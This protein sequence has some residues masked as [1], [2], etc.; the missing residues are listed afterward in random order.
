MHEYS[1][2]CRSI[3]STE[4]QVL[5]SMTKDD[6][7]TTEL[8]PLND[9]QSLPE[10]PNTKLPKKPASHPWRWREM[11]TAAFIVIDYFLLYSSMS[12]IGVF[13]PAEVCNNVLMCMHYK[14]Y[15]ISNN[16]CR[17]VRK[18]PQCL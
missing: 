13:F 1:C 8:M 3:A 14:S 15:G 2:T 9:Q 6:T 10:S 11:I 12:L 16:K 17:L 18:E 4:P 5:K 7:N